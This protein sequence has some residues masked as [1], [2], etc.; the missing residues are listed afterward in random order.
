MHCVQ[1][2]GR[3]CGVFD[4]PRIPIM[5]VPSAGNFPVLCGARVPE[6]AQ[7]GCRMVDGEE[8]CPSKCRCRNHG[9]A[10]IRKGKLQ[11]NEKAVPFRPHHP[12]T[13]LR[14][15]SR[16][17][18]PPLVDQ[19]WPSSLEAQSAGSK[20]VSSVSLCQQVLPEGHAEIS[21]EVISAGDERSHCNRVSRRQ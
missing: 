19:A 11:F 15:S 4:M 14:D 6:E 10:E 9:E 3:S 18:Q 2:P 7:C 8:A 12:W 17:R 13:V 1:S 20:S 5:S 21:G 16:R